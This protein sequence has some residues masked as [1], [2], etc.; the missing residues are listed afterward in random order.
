MDLEEKGL[1]QAFE[2]A[3]A[4]QIP[5]HYIQDFLSDPAVRE[6]TGTLKGRGFEPQQ[7]E[8]YLIGLYRG[9]EHKISLAEMASIEPCDSTEAESDTPQVLVL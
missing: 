8:Q 9:G 1:G 5:D 7:I 3:D 6:L 4:P 2:I